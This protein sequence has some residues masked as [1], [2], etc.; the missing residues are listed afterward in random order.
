MINKIG[1][2]AFLAVMLSLI[3]VCLASIISDR[4]PRLHKYSEKIDDVLF[5]LLVTL[6]GLSIICGIYLI[7]YGMI[8]I[9]E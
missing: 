9:W 4:V 1:A 3:I 7:I 8:K 2:T 5:G 6:I